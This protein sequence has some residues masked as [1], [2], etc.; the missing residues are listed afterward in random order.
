MTDQAPE[1]QPPAEVSYQVT[2]FRR[3]PGGQPGWQQHTSAECGADD[4]IGFIEQERDQAAADG[5]GESVAAAA[6]IPAQSAAPSGPQPEQSLPATD[7][8]PV[9]EAG[10]DQ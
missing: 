1:A 10:N 5:L 4:A 6:S 9:T 3:P 2:V 7:G 8:S